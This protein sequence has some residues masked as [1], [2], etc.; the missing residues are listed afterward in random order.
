MVDRDSRGV[1]QNFADGNEPGMTSIRCLRGMRTRRRRA[2]ARGLFEIDQ[3]RCDASL[4]DSVRPSVVQ[5]VDV[6]GS[7]D[8]IRAMGSKHKRPWAAG[9]QQRRAEKFQGREEGFARG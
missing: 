1:T 6:R 8:T 2:M 5:G 9:T 4:F 7:R 3:A